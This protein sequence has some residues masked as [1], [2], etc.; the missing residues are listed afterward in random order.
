M[1]TYNAQHPLQ[2]GYHQTQCRITV[3]LDLDKTVCAP[4]CGKNQQLSED[5][6]QCVNTS[7]NTPPPIKCTG[8]TP[9]PCLATVGVNLD[10]TVCGP[11]CG[12]NQQLSEDCS[13]CIS[14]SISAPP[15]PC[16]SNQV[17]CFA[18]VGVNLGK[19]VCG[20]TC[21]NPSQQ[22]SAD[23]SH[24][25]YA[26]TT[27]PAPAPSPT[28]RNPSPCGANQVPCFAI[29]G[30][31]LGN[32]VCGPNCIS[33]KFVHPDCSH[34]ID[35]STNTHGP[36]TY[37]YSNNPG[38]GPGPSPK[39][40]PPPPPPPK[41]S[42]GNDKQTLSGPPPKDS[43]SKGGGSNNS[44]AGKDSGGPK[45][46]AGSG[47]GAGSPNGGKK[48]GRRRLSLLRQAEVVEKVML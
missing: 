26:S 12:K 28:P 30:V 37:P 43:I 20:P 3:G 19:T 11:Q 31:N 13:T 4:Q 9:I 46:A 48:Q 38:P 7:P 34:C 10:K 22:V 6:L 14:T 39:T 33:P 23:C 15:S 21:V 41:S 45:N 8:K 44:P 5:C 16:N 2:C 32:V 42:S 25:V 47:A 18:T 17:P 24:C 35:P 36:D 40:S 1:D 29:V 27:P